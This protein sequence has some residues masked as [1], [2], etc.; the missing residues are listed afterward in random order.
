MNKERYLLLEDIVRHMRVNSDCSSYDNNCDVTT[1]VI[2]GKSYVTET[3]Y[4][5][6]GKVKNQRLY[7]QE[8]SWCAL[9]YRSSEAIYTFGDT[10]AFEKDLCV[11]K[12][13]IR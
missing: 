11:L 13:F 2:L 7:P 10:D 8:K 1:Y 4:D 9:L 3:K 5:Q 6:R 12:L